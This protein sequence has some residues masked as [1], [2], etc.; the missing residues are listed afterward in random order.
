MYQTLEEI[1]IISR[2][3]IYNRITSIYEFAWSS[4]IQKFFISMY[5]EMFTF[6]TQSE[7]SLSSFISAKKFLFSDYFWYNVRKT[8]EKMY[9]SPLLRKFQQNIKQ[10]K[11][12]YVKFGPLSFLECTLDKQTATSNQGE[13]KVDQ[14]LMIM[15]RRD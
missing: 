10:D 3:D 6:L 9:Y 5:N 1:H 2:T 8:L 15:L 12:I 7:N 13:W 14:Q 11:H 4:Q